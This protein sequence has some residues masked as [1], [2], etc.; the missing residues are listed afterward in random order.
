MSLFY[1]I[2]SDIMRDHIMPFTYRPQ[3][4]NLLEDILSYHKII[5]NVKAI[6]K[7]RWAS[8]AEEDSDLAW[9][10][11]DITRFLNN[12]QATM[13]GICDFYKSVFR[14]LYVQQNK[15]LTNVTIP[16]TMGCSNFQDINISIGLLSILERADLERFL[17][18]I[19]D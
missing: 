2:P 1:H 15:T 14:R 4:I 5:L 17:T 11:N 13:M 9:L 16:P 8:S 18:D 6:Y 7:A 10:S 3:S 12:D 19:V